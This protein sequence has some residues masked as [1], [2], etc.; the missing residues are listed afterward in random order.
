MTEC[1]SDTIEKYFKVF[2]ELTWNFLLSLTTFTLSLNASCDLWRKFYELSRRLQGELNDAGLTLAC[3]AARRNM[4][5][6]GFLKLS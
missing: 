4:F 2:Y 6:Y 5:Y 3:H 1:F